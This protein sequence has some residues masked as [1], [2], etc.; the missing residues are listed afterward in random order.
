MR[1]APL[2]VR[3]RAIAVAGHGV[4][5]AIF[6]GQGT[7][8][9]RAVARRLRRPR[10][11]PPCR[12]RRARARR[13]SPVAPCTLRDARACPPPGRP[14]GRQLPTSS[15]YAWRTALRWRHRTRCPG[16]SARRCTA[17]DEMRDAPNSQS[18]AGPTSQEATD[19][20]WKYP[21]VGGRERR[22]WELARRAR[23]EQHARDEDRAAMHLPREQPSNV[24]P[25]PAAP[26]AE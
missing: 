3:G 6:G 13:E 2:A 9:T 10:H 4:Q 21:P 8:V 11:G 15:P 17:F 1:P 26:F 24:D 22:R 25:Y 14:V 5:S 7:S 20:A 12:L 19:S 23:A 18:S 16:T